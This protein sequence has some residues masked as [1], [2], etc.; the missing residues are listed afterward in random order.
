[1]SAVNRGQRAACVLRLFHTLAER[2]LTGYILARAI[3]F[4]MMGKDLFEAAQWFEVAP[5][6]LERRIAECRANLGELAF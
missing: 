4:R 6:E 2:D 3:G 5:A 1:M